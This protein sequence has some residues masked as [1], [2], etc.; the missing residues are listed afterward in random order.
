MSIPPVSSSSSDSYWSYTGNFEQDLLN[1]KTLLALQV[2]NMEES[3]IDIALS[4]QF[5]QSLQELLE[6]YP[7]QTDAITASLQDQD[8]KAF[9]LKTVEAAYE[10]SYS[11][12]GSLTEAE[13]A[14][15][16]QID[17][18]KLLFP[19]TGDISD[20]F[21]ALKSE[22]N[23]CSIEVLNDFRTEE[24]KSTSAYLDFRSLLA[25]ALIKLRKVTDNTKTEE[26]HEAILALQQL[27]E[28]A[29]QDPTLQGIYEEVLKSVFITYDG[30]LAYLEEI[31]FDGDNSYVKLPY[32]YP[33]QNSLGDLLNA[34]FASDNNWNGLKDLLPSTLENSLLKISSSG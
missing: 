33:A 11:Q 1:F 2:A 24:L 5:F 8:L 22:I 13:T 28:A 12:T 18:F 29:Q 6:K 21:Y 17:K 15:Q 4:E 27:R 9:F 16:S 30:T 25:Q 23:A 26:M 19:S 32:E 14:A 10:K 31:F 3:A 20:P 7:N 34:M